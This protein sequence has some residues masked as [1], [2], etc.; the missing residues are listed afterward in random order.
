MRLLAKP[1]TL[2]VVLGLLL[3]GAV[4][5]LPNAGLAAPRK[6]RV[7]CLAS[8]Y[9]RVAG[10][11]L[12][13]SLLAKRAPDC[14]PRVK[15]R[16][17]RTPT[18][19]Q[20]ARPSPK[21]A[22]KPQLQQRAQFSK[23]DQDAAVIPGIRDARFW[24]D[25]EA[26]FLAALGTAKG[27]WL[28]LSAGGED[29]AFAAG[30]LNGLSESGKRP[31][32]TV[33]T[34]VSSGALL[35][36][37]VFLGPARDAE[38]RRDF[39][40]ITAADVFEDVKRA[41]SLFD[42]WPLRDFIAKRITPQLLAEIAVEHRRGRRLFVLTANIDAA[43]PVAWN[44]GA[45]AAHGDETA[46]KLFR[47]V[48]LASGSVP[49]VFPPVMIDVEANGRRFQEM[50]VDGGLGATIFVAPDSLL[51]NSSS[52]RLPAT[53]LTIIVN[54]KLSSEFAVIDRSLPIILG[55]ALTLGVKRGTRAAIAVIA[56]AAQRSGTD[57]N[58]AYV[59]E[60]FDVPSRG[61][62]DPEYMQALYEFGARQGRSA[63]PFLHAPPRSSRPNVSQ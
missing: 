18:A 49:G 20:Q 41:D 25:S 61:L 29:A 52:S 27:T 10:S 50:H 31:E 22:P 55:R 43:R 21:L 17:R 6:E 42:T 39:T 51:L 58:L 13:K 32:Y 24:A 1:K 28:A 48:L 15:Y 30:L 2:A 47:D 19:R 63:E 46:L 33:V 16:S 11:A 44:M 8:Q 38:L 45:I 59:D 26:E 5:M 34:G 35:A 37:F 40:T 3:A 23:E 54:G 60:G 56:A 4:A 14:R 36:P 7:S 62:F 53:Q 9:V 57:F 12:P